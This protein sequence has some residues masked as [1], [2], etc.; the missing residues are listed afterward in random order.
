MAL[1][2][3]VILFL[4]KVSGRPRQNSRVNVFLLF[5]LAWSESAEISLPNWMALKYLFCCTGT[6]IQSYCFSCQHAIPYDGSFLV[7]PGTGDVTGEDAALCGRGFLGASQDP[8][9][10]GTLPL[11]LR[12]KA[13]PP[14]QLA[15]GLASLPSCFHTMHSHMLVSSGVLFANLVSYFALSV[16]L[17]L[18]Q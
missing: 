6:L 11:T 9:E 5:M 2:T 17:L 18:R 15:M 10:P 7:G 13:K 8:S 16:R 4:G 3:S 12:T 14:P 1:L